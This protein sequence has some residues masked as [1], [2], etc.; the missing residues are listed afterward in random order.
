MKSHQQ[1]LI[2]IEFVIVSVIVGIFLSLAIP[3][4]RDFLICRHVHHALLLSEAAQLAV[5]QIVLAQEHF[6]R[7]QT[8]TGFISPQPTSDVA[9]VEIANDGSGVVIVTMSAD[10]G[11]GTIEFAPSYTPGKPLSWDCSGGT[12][13]DKYRPPECF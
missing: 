13:D 1:G 6:P 11:G 7:N 12:L 10:A 5:S 9:S 3:A 4:V 8:E 2:A